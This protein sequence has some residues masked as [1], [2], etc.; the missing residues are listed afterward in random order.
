MV[1]DYIGIKKDMLEAVKKYGSPQENPI[2]ELD[3]SLSIFRNYLAM[4]DELLS[5]FDATRFY[6]GTPLARLN[7]LNDAAEYV[8]TIKERQTRF[9]GLSRRMKSA[10]EICF[11]SG[12]LTGRETATAQFY[13]AIRSIIY[14][15]SSLQLFEQ[16]NIA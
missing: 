4:I 11:P 14:K 10:Y 13:M 16:I 1:V 3:V 2:D 7:C 5:D 6:Q 8:Q 15:H 9:M 12:E